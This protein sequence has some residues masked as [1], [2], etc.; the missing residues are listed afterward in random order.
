MANDSRHFLVR[1]NTGAPAFFYS[2]TKESHTF[3]NLLKYFKSGKFSN[4]VENQ[5]TKF[6]NVTRLIGGT[7]EWYDYKNE[8]MFQVKIPVN[9]AGYFE[10][11]FYNYI[12]PH[13]A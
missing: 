11:T 7:I 10:T 3:D 13:T 1:I 12:Y 5:I 9:E 6:L 4:S 8:A 2:D